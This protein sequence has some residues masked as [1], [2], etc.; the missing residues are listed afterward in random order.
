QSDSKSETIRSA[1]GSVTA[2][3]DHHVAVTFGDSGFRLYL[4]GQL[5]DSEDDFTQGMTE[6]DNSL[7]LGASTTHRDGNRMNLRD[8]FEGELASFDFYAEQLSDDDI[9][10][11]STGDSTPDPESA[12]DPA[13]AQ[14]SAGNHDEQTAAYSRWMS[15]TIWRP[16]DVDAYFSRSAR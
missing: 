3:E 8:A 15:R 10:G 5:V 2:G 16:D 1:V 7:V 6:N 12:I 13:L 4:D 11:L 14:V 9:A